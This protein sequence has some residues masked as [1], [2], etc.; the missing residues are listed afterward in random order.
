MSVQ[1]SAKMQVAA[2]QALKGWFEAARKDLDGMAVPVLVDAIITLGLNHDVKQVQKL[3]QDA[4]DIHV[5]FKTWRIL[6]S[7]QR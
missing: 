1:R 7:Q 2:K 6:H 3:K 4:C 5:A